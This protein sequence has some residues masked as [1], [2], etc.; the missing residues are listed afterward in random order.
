VAVDRR[1]LQHNMVDVDTLAKQ[2]AAQRQ[3]AA[4]K[5]VL[6]GVTAASDRS[7]GSSDQSPALPVRLP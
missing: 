7:D 6:I 1:P 5:E 2:E 4:I 3:A